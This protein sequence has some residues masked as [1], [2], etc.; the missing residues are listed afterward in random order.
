MPAVY[1]R[2]RQ[3]VAQHAPHVY[4]YQHSLRHRQAVVPP[5]P[6]PEPITITELP[7]PPVTAD[8]G[9]GGCTLEINPHGT[10]CIGKSPALQNGDF[11]PDDLHVVATVNFTGAPASPD[12]ASIYSGQQLIVVK[13]DN[14]TFPNGDAWKCITCG[15][16]AE[17]QAG[18]VANHDYPQIFN[19]G[20]RLLAGPQIIECS[21]KLVSEACTPDQVHI[22]PIRW[23]TAVNGS[24]IGGTIRELRIHPDNEHL[25]F[26]SFTVTSGKVS[27]FAYIG[28]L[29]LNKAPTTGEPLVP[30]YDL[31][32]V[33]LLFSLNDTQPVEVDSEDSTLLRINYDAITVGELRGFSG[34]GKEVTY[35]GYP[36]E[37]SNIDV[38]AADLAT[39]KVRRLT[40][41]PEYT[42]PVDIS[43]DDQWTVAMD[44]RGSG[45]QMFMA[46]LRGI[47]PLTDLVATSA[48][49]STRNN[50]GRRFFQPWL[51]DGHGDRES[52]FGQQLNAEG[53]G[54]PGSGA[55]NDPEWNGRADPKW[56][57]DGTHI[58]YYQALTV[59]PECGGE[60]PLPCYPSTAPG[61]RTERM[62]LAHLTSR[63]PLAPQPV[64][65]LSDTIPWATPYVPGSHVPERP[66]P[67]N[68]NFT[69]KGM[70]S[71]W[72][73]IIITPN[74]GGG[75]PGTVAVEYHD[76]SDDGTNVLVGSEKVTSVNP[77][78]TVEEIDWYSDLVQTGPNN[79]TKKSSPDGFRLSIDILTNIFQ[80]NGTLT[81]T[82]D[83]KEW[84]QPAN[85]T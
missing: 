34:T 15:V 75:L 12:P 76:F 65:P 32:N 77:S 39:G 58:V 83:G 62:M 50:R 26:N 73:N 55:I 45:R 1:H 68:G 28:R 80:A 74:S 44:T 33:N 17:N 60:N 71:G 29:V 31:A 59:S 13:I 41:H 82:I 37:S 35:I 54:V 10:G 46:G 38:F 47:P 79:G 84:L 66:F 3:V 49:S 48:A 7:L 30:R 57:N 5:P 27:Q 70:A 78:P 36:V 52:Y 56:S 43:P 63:Q 18:R 22:Y 24:G 25:G 11:L 69:L 51:I 4:F 42:D 21:V 23:N 8:E 14:S 53:S 61:G 19:D 16:P 85:G 81:T 64:E 72:A 6:A 40:A 67:T 2:Y 9:V 20:K